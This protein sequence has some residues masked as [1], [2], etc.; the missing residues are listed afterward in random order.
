M[1]MLPTLDL[2][3]SLEP[4]GN[5]EVS[6]CPNAENFRQHYDQ[7]IEKSEEDDHEEKK[8]SVF[9]LAAEQKI[10]PIF[11]HPQTL[12]PSSPALVSTCETK[13]APLAK[14][15]CEWI[16][17]EA[18][19]AITHTIQN[20]VKETSLRLD[21]PAFLNS[22]FQGI[23]LVIKEFSTAPLSFNIE[24]R[25]SSTAISSLKPH[26]QDLR[27]AFYGSHRPEGYAIHRIETSY[28]DSSPFLFHRKPPA[29]GS[30]L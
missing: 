27:A 25:G 29:E 1:K 19:S 10:N 17:K 22:P 30:N 14:T 6:L 5:E 11:P 2:C 18:T 3:D 7:T 26:L 23:E 16:I 15:Q 4:P 20:G 8:Q 12:V 28:E 21:G 9:D 24:F 13:I